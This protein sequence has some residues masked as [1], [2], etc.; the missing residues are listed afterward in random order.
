V[1]ATVFLT[2]SVEFGLGDHLKD[3]VATSP[4]SVSTNQFHQWLFTTCAITSIALGKL[5]II[6]FI[7]QI[8]GTSQ[9]SKRK[10]ILYVFAVSNV[11]V[12]V[13][14]IP[15]IWVQ[16]TPTAKMWDEALE[17]NCRGRARNQTYGYFQGSKKIQGT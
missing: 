3:L 15:I 4:E 14:I 5:A 11:L 8:E 7:L 13:I 1:L 6:S 17:G 9:G 16:C 2:V 10:W 12:N